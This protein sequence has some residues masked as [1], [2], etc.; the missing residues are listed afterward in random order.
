MTLR[1][2][3]LYVDLNNFTLTAVANSQVVLV[4][5]EMLSFFL[6]VNFWGPGQCVTIL[7]LV[8]N[9]RNIVAFIRQGVRDSVNVSLLGLTI[10]DLGSLVFLFFLN[11]CWTPP[12]MKQDLPFYPQ[13]IMYF[14]FWGHVIFTRVTTGTT[15]WVTFERCLCIVAP[16]KIKS[17]ITVRRT[18]AV[19]VVLYTV[20]L[21]GI[22]PMF[23]T[24]R[25]TW[26]FDYRRN[27]SLLG[28]VKIANRGSLETV[29][30][31]VNNILPML[32]FLLIV[33]CT[34][35]LTIT[36]QTNAKWRQQTSANKGKTVS[37]RDSKV[38][39]MVLLI[40]AV[41]VF[42]YAPSAVFFVWPLTDKEI[43]IDGI[44]RNLAI[45]VFSLLLHLEGINA[46]ANFFIYIKMSS[47][48]RATLQDLFCLREPDLRSK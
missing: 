39:K 20:V 5:D 35:M 24:S 22:G 19:I 42:S 8:V 38:I 1:N 4:T 44:Q 10:S 3:T 21:C 30:F 32:F 16:L 37:N 27:K 26:I 34:A 23:Y 15:A 43:K 7:G 46:S 18:V 12:I 28:F 6:M 41:F 14:M 29:V 25:F 45:A 48:F 2:D 36:L 17:I 40:S 31:L 47:K 33:A 11:L 9:I 13:Q